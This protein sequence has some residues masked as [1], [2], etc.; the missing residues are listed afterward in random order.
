MNHLI[1]SYL[2]DLMRVAYNNNKSD[3]S[4]IVKKSSRIKSHTNSKIIFDYYTSINHEILFR[5]EFGL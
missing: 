1:D 2:D 5:V 4:K 3:L